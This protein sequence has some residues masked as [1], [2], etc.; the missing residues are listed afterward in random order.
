MI[1]TETGYQVPYLAAK[2]HQFLQSEVPI[3]AP[4]DQSGD[5]VAYLL[6]DGLWFGKVFV[7]M[8]YRQSKKLIILHI[9]VA[10]REYARKIERDLEHLRKLGYRFTGIVSDG[11]TG[12]VSAVNEIFPHAPH[13]ICLAHMHRRL[14][15]ALG[16]YPKDYRVKRLKNLADHIWL[17]ESREALS[18][19]RDQVTTW[20]KENLSFM[21]ERRYDSE[22]KWWYIH[23]GVRA[24]VRIMTRLPKTSFMF[25][26][27]DPLMPKTTNELEAQFGHLGRRWSSHRGLKKTRW[28]QYLNWFVYLYNLEKLS[29]SSQKSVGVTNTGS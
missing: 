2:F 6:I 25:L 5:D 4:L 9:S 11:G 17:L 19:W 29:L 12:I 18:W 14:L 27:G 3:L 16:K 15:A 20:I 23:K 21:C 22:G 13:Q 8:V 28:Q 1:A 10:S 24:A 26:H 7:L